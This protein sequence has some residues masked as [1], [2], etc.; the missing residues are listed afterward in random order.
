M[1]NGTIQFSVPDPHLPSWN[2]IYS[3]KHWS[4]RS[5]KAKELHQLIAAYIP[6]E[7]KTYKG[8]VDIRVYNYV[9]NK[10]R[11]MDADN[12]CDKFCI[13]ALIDRVIKDDR[14]VRL[15][16]SRCEVD[17]KNP[18]VDIEIDLLK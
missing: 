14:Q 11:L 13:D 6:R 1:N 15:A 7:I 16:S 5:S 17:R 18:R 8:S 9:P 10:R 2:S 4:F 3:G 12:V